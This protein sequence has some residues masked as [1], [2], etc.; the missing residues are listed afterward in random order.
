M[1]MILRSFYW[2]PAQKSS[3]NE[4]K[5]NSVKAIENWLE[6]WFANAESW[7]IC[8]S[9]KLAWRLVCKCWNLVDLQLLK[10]GW[11]ENA[12]SWLESW[13]ENSES[14]L[15]CKCWKLVHLKMLKGGLKVALQMLKVGWLAKCGKLGE[16]LT[17]QPHISPISYCHTVYIIPQ[18]VWWWWWWWW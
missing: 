1:M 15:I 12:E 13:L 5:Q 10:V 2:N 8:K 4:T 11:F 18:S 7:L 6:S 3:E 16:F 14:W 9:W 17:P